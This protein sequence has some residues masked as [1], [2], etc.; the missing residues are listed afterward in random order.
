MNTTTENS[1]WADRYNRNLVADAIER[2]IGQD[3]RVTLQVSDFPGLCR[4]DDVFALIS[5]YADDADNSGCRDNEME[6]W[7]DHDGDA[8][9]LRVV[10]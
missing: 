7:G 4:I 9:A 8:F 3:R 10:P 1:A 2:S 5:A 6:V